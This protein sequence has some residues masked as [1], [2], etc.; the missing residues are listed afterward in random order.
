MFHSERKTCKFEK[1]NIFYYYY[2]HHYN[3]KLSGVIC[4]FQEHERTNINKNTIITS[5]C[6]QN[7]TL[8]IE[9]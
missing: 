8:G 2:H 4:N 7:K 1:S 3:Y 9:I 5:N 6:P